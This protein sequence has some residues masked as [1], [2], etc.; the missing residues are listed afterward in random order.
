[1]KEVRAL[2]VKFSNKE[3]TYEV[4]NEDGEVTKEGII[5]MYAHCNVVDIDSE[6]SQFVEGMVNAKKIVSKHVLPCTFGGSSYYGLCE[7]GTTVNVIPYRFNFG[8]Q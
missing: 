8:N 5:A 2:E 3:P 1:V 7:I 6:T 4:A